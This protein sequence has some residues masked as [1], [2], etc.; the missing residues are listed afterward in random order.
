MP[1]D[2]VFQWWS[3]SDALHYAAYCV[4]ALVR[5][6]IPEKSTSVRQGFQYDRVEARLSYPARMSWM[7]RGSRCCD[8]WCVG[9]VI[10]GYCKGKQFPSMVTVCDWL[11][12]NGR[13][14]VCDV[15]ICF[16]CQLL[17]IMRHY[18]SLQRVET[19]HWILGYA[20]KMQV[21]HVRDKRSRDRIVAVIS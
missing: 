11:L 5:N 1:V 16:T 12:L 18:P 7:R 3:E 4:L 17:G 8:S 9:N 20:A 14:Q 13:V 10:D 15:I 21:F 6:W 2:M 19:W